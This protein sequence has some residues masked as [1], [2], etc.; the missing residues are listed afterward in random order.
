[1]PL[2]DEDLWRKCKEQHDTYKKTEDED[3]D[4]AKQMRPLENLL[5]NKKAS[6]QRH[7][8][9]C[10]LLAERIKLVQRLHKERLRYIELDCDKFDWFNR[11]TTKAQRL[12]D[13]QD[14]LNNVDDRLKNLYALNKRFC[15]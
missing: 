6:A 13:H 9:F 3:T 1:M 14:T 10:S 11:G 7:T 2:V 8:D 15:Q 4:F 5:Q 12:A